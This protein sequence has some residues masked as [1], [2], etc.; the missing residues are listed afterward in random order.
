[1]YDLVMIGGGIVGLSVAYHAVAAGARTLPIDRAD[2]GRAAAAGAGILAPETSSIESDDWLRLAV[3]PVDYYPA[4]VAQLQADGADDTG[5]AA[6]E[7]LIVA[8]TEDEDA[9]FASTRF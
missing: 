6:T 7:A 8:V 4:L 5:Y 9:P 2:M 1:M 3:A